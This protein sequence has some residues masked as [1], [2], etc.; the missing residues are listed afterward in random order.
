MQINCFII[1]L[2]LILFASII[3]S[4]SNSEIVERPKINESPKINSQQV[5]SE[6][7]IE[8][9]FPKVKKLEAF[10]KTEFLM[11]L[12]QPINKDKNCIYAASL[13]FCWDEI[14]KVVGDQI[15]IDKKFADLNLL[16]N[17]KS[18]VM[19]LQ[20]NEYTSSVEFQKQ[21]IIAKAEFKKSLPFEVKLEDLH[22]YVLKFDNLKVESF[23]LKSYNKGLLDTFTILYYQD[24]DNFI[25]KLNPKNKEHEIVLF[26][27]S[28]EILTTLTE[29]ISAMHEKIELGKQEMTEEDYKW[30]YEFQPGNILAIPKLKF[31]I[32]HDY[33]SLVGNSFVSIKGNWLINKAWQKTSF[34]I[35]HN[36]AVIASE[37]ELEVLSAGKK[38]KS[39]PKVKIMKFDKPFLLV[40]K[41]ADNNNPYFAMWV[42][43][44]E[45]MAKE[46]DQF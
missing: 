25:I 27:S 31:N 4:C 39:L 40:M 29:T 45:L 13:L 33:K 46:D 30:C 44:T 2:K 22:F 9:N 36:G 1:Y 16:N 20:P 14:R 42:A 3:F 32:E 15:V 10:P 24:D 35:D 17:A 19:V 8:S 7:P 41:R 18:H 23:G 5:F 11:T 12:E 28:L 37:A 43:N 6:N 34:Q 26:K 38:V 21:K